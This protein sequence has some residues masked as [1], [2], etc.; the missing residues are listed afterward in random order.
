M[1]VCLNEKYCEIQWDEVNRTVIVVY[2]GYISSDENR[3]I[4]E[5]MLEILVKYNSNR[6]LHDSRNFFTIRPEDQEWILKDW[7]PRVYK[8][9]GKIKTAG[10]IPSGTIQKQVIDKMIAA[11]K[12]DRC[13]SPQ[14]CETYEAALSWLCK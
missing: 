14:F 6:V 1:F 4:H 2:K 7:S 5:K 10:I 3:Y 12:S 11:A 8:A 13:S 9:V